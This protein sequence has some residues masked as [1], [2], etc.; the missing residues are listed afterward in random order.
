[1]GSVIVKGMEMPKNCAYCPLSEYRNSSIL[2]CK[3]IGT[4]GTAS[5]DTH[6]VLNRRHPNCPLIEIPTPHGRL[7]DIK[8]VEDRKFTTVDNE[9]ERWW[10]GALDSVVD[11]APTVIEAEGGEE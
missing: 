3:Q 9:Y 5:R 6:N 1:M 11:N 4:V 2:D 10:N 8:S 7:V